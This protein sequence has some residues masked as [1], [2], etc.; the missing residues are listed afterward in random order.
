M[1]RAGVGRPR[2][3]EQEMKSAA[4][5]WNVREG[6]KCLLVP[7]KSVI[8]TDPKNKRQINKKNTGGLIKSHSMSYERETLV[9]Q[10]SYSDLY[11]TLKQ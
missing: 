10:S 3:W 1:Q 4:S 11:N 6:I 9:T 8:G 7:H 2:S 5:H